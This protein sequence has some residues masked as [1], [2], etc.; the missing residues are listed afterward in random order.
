METE[1]SNGEVSRAAAA[2]PNPAPRT[3]PDNSN[4]PE[5]GQGV[6]EGWC[7]L[8]LLRRCRIRTD[9]ALTV[10][11]P[12][13]ACWIAF[14]EA[15]DPPWARCSR[16]TRPGSGAGR[17][18]ACRPGL[19]TGW[20]QRLP[21]PTHAP[22]RH[23]GGARQGPARSGAG[24]PEP[25]HHLGGGITPPERGLRRERSAHPR[26]GD[27]AASRFS[28]RD[29]SLPETLKHLDPR[30]RLAVVSSARA[31]LPAAGRSAAVVTGRGA[32]GI[33]ACAGAAE[34]R[35]AGR[36]TCRT[37]YPT[38]P[39]PDPTVRFARSKRLHWAN[40]AFPSDETCRVA[41][42]PANRVRPIAC[43]RN[44]P[45]RGSGAAACRRAPKSTAMSSTTWRTLR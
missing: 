5:N 12:N 34:R 11:I 35:P 31:T 7:V 45:R 19:A 41:G 27:P 39:L 2:V 10:Q 32:H 43:C 38:R 37:R 28:R 23:P 18:A 3:P 42:R 36:V 6:Q 24:R 44:R 22:Q 1:R 4:D 9:P 21:T 17:G 13:S 20:N 14:E 40:G 29:G 15:A 16:A 26:G 30:L 33:P 25:R 8:A